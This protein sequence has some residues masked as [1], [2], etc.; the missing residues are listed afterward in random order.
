MKTKSFFLIAAIA[1]TIIST[2]NA[3]ATTWRVNNITSYNQW[4][5]QQVFSNLQTAVNSAFVLDGDT[6]MVEATVTNYG[7]VTL[8]KKLTIIGSGYFLNE[9]IGLQHQ[10]IPTT[11][12]EIIFNTGSSGSYLCGLYITG[13]QNN[14][15]SIEF[16]NV[17]LDHITITRC[18]VERGLSIMCYAGVNYSFITLTKNWFGGIT[19]NGGSQTG[20]ADNVIIMNNYFNTTIN[21][22]SGFAATISQNVF[23]G[24]INIFA[25]NVFYNNI[26]M[27][28]FSQLDNGENNVHH[29]LFKNAYSTLNWLVDPSSGGTNRFGVPTTTIFNTTN[30]STDSDKKVNNFA[31]CPDCYIGLPSGTDEVGMFGGNDP[32]ILSGIPNFPTIYN[33][34]QPSTAVQGGTAPVT[35]KSRSNN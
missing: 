30:P 22:P 10:S 2:L 26:C 5:N 33:L 18:F 19:L 35:I 28:T 34:V 11:I 31:T 25:S 1:A 29:N 17:N 8:G 20:T 12:T 9:N 32:Y 24:G 14:A 13:I 21:L 27:S 7:I 3:Y 4:T 16:T 15:P 6:L 23:N